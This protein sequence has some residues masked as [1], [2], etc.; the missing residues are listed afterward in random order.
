VLAS[1]FASFVIL[2]CLDLLTAHQNLRMRPALL[3]AEPRSHGNPAVRQY[4]P[5]QSHRIR[6]YMAN[7]NRVPD[8]EN[9][10]LSRPS[11]EEP[12]L[13][14]NGQEMRER[15]PG[16]ETFHGKPHDP[17]FEDTLD[18]NKDER[19][20]T[21]L[22][23]AAVL[24]SKPGPTV[25]VW[26]AFLGVVLGVLFSLLMFWRFQT[27]SPRA[28][29]QAQVQS[30]PIRDVNTFITDSFLPLVVRHRIRLK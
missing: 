3:V 20:N 16:W 9:R 8:D 19:Y 14:A 29:M 28:P 27:P 13:S 10:D 26:F 25:W 23:G 18:P 22:K 7:P 2:G 11:T 15:N 21:N 5:R 1:S 4:T 30:A 17:R 6:H 24:P 12:L